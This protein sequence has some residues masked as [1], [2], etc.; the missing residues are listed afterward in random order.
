MPDTTTPTERDRLKEKGKI[1]YNLCP[2]PKNWTCVLAFIDKYIDDR[3][4][5]VKN[6]LLFLKEEILQLEKENQ[7]P[8]LEQAKKLLMII[9]EKLTKSR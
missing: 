5:V 4:I 7:H 6:F 3:R 2:D 1:I 9:E 8:R